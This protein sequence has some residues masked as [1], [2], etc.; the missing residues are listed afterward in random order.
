VTRNFPYLLGRLH[1][2][3]DVMM[4]QETWNNILG[5]MIAVRAA[6]GWKAA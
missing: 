2:P 3:G 4:K 5:S 1:V 6:H